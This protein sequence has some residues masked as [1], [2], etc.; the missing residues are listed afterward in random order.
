MVVKHSIKSNQNRAWHAPNSIKQVRQ[1]VGFIG[2]YRRFIQDF[3][4]LSE[5]LVALARKGVTFAWTDPQQ[6]AFDTLKSCL[7][8]NPILGFP[9]EDGRFILDT[10]ASLFAV[11][12]VLNQLQEDR[13]VVIVYASRSL[14]VSQRCIARLAGRCWRRLL[15]APTSRRTYVVLSSPCL[16]MTTH[17]GGCRNFGI[18]T[19]CWSVG[20]CCWASF[21]LNSSIYRGP[22][23]LI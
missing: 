19:V 9:T 2:Y 10:D 4:G 13:E 15:C 1:F 23:M 12:G 7:L 14:R 21:Q 18:V 6:V 3:A 11:E 5:P 20:T 22:N 17:F 8:N 16:R